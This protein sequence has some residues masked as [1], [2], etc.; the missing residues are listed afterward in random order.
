MT[1]WIQKA[2]KEP[3]ALHRDL[4]IPKGQKI[5]ASQL[6]V[7]PGDSPKLSKRKSL[8]KTLSKFK[9]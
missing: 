6:T 9:K 3:G 2:I 7:K 1:N 8:A 4:G 5:P